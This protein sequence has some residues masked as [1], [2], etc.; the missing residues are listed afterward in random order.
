MCL[1][2]NILL[3]LVGELS[4][5]KLKVLSQICKSILTCSNKITMLEISRYTEVAYRTVQRFF[6]LKDIVWEKLNLC[7]FKRFVWNKDKVFLIAAD[8][9]VEKKS[10]KKTF[11]L[12][13]F[14][15]NIEKQ[16]IPAISF[17][18]MSL[19]DVI[20][21]KSYPMITKQLVKP[22][23][24]KKTTNVTEKEPKAK[25]SKGRPKGSKNK[26]KESSTDIQ[27][28]IL[29]TLL[30]TLKELLIANLNLFPCLYLTLDGYFGNQYYMRLAKKYSV[31]LISKLKCNSALFFA[32]EGKTK[33]RGHPPKYGEKVNVKNLH[34]KYHKASKI[35]DK[36]QYDFYQM[37]LWSK[38][39]TE[40][41]LNVVVIICK[42]L[43]TKSTSHCILFS[44][45]LKLSH[46]KI[47]EYYG[48]RFQIEFNFR[49]AKQYFGL[50]DFKNYKEVQVTNAVNL[51]FF[52]CNFSYI[53]TKDFKELFNVEVVSIL[54]LKTY[55]RTE[56]IAKATLELKNKGK[57][58]LHFLNPFQIF[59]IAKN[60]AV[61]F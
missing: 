42:N 43:K 53:L 32:W 17:M 14:F 30:K 55:Y 11:G 44:T 54:D 23:K 2:N 46:D 31:D 56:F 28:T 47:V 40:A 4:S 60:Q 8:E 6:S 29:E 45:D 61:N 34:S 38:N 5:T 13:H 50:A 58:A 48:L 19:V 49:D 12:S 51:A 7:L 27:Y 1:I 26:P 36:F 21:R 3:A 22:E 37:H 25:R 59:T 16:A 52:M 39:Y 20:Q 35:E 15:S 10:G 18:N 24:E 33:G 9:V 41:M 57:K